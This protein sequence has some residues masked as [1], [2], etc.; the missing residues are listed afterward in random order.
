M[1][2]TFWT[3]FHKFW[4][5]YT[6]RC[7]M[8][9]TKDKL[10]LFFGFSPRKLRQRT[11]ALRTFDLSEIRRL[12]TVWHAFKLYQKN[13]KK[14]SKNRPVV[15]KGNLLSNVSLS[16]SPGL[17]SIILTIC[18]DLNCSSSMWELHDHIMN[19][20]WNSLI[21]YEKFWSV[22]QIY[23][24]IFLEN[25]EVGFP[26]GKRTWKII[27]TSYAAM[28]ARS[29]VPALLYLELQRSYLSIYIS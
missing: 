28:G 27:A 12:L 16:L 17:S 2:T 1:C 15:T 23:Y 9:Y 25:N 10:V 21:S 22:Y 14:V 7:R 24:I 18:N 13:S 19:Y 6:N 4:R 26:W 11:T 20:K 5:V 29:L 8:G 3:F